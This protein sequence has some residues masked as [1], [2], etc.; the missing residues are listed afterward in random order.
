MK[1]L[2]CHLLSE[3]ETSFNYFNGLPD[4][5]FVAWDQTWHQEIGIILVS[6]PHF[7]YLRWTWSGFYY[8]HFTA[9]SSEAEKG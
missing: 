8:L 1:L 6:G 2:M 5:G 9:G 4:T 3:T 7:S